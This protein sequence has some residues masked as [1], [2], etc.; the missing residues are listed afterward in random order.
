MLDNRI[1]S[2]NIVCAT[3][4]VARRHAC[5][6]G[7]VGRKRLFKK[8]NLKSTFLTFVNL[9]WTHVAAAAVQ[10]I[11]ILMFGLEDGNK[12][13]RL[14]LPPIVLRGGGRRG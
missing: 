2:T 3:F 1:N 12:E 5:R 11:I 6:V 13:E 9:V 4:V 10:T 8:S 7:H 14:L